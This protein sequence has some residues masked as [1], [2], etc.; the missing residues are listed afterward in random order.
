M[1]LRN[2]QISTASGSTMFIALPNNGALDTHNKKTHQF[3]YSFHTIMIRPIVDVRYTHF[4]LC[5]VHNRYVVGWLN[6][7]LCLC[8]LQVT[9]KCLYTANVKPDTTLHTTH[10]I[11]CYV[12]NIPYSCLPI[13]GVVNWY[14]HTPSAACTPGY[15]RTRTHFLFTTSS[16]ST[17]T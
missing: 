13:N 2:S 1:P 9:L 17:Y 16:L 7:Q 3:N 14:I 6:V 11:L 12:H 10:I 8:I 5:L 4:S 15:N